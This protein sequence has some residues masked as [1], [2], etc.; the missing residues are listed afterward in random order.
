MDYYGGTRIGPGVLPH[1]QQLGIS[2]SYDEMSKKLHIQYLLWMELRKLKSHPLLLIPSW[3]G[4]F[5]KIRDN[6]VVIQ[7]TIGYLDTLDS[8]ATD[9]KTAYEVLCRG[10]EIKDRLQLK[11]VACVFD[12]AFYAKAMEVIWKQKEQFEGL[13][14]MMGG[15]HLLMTLLAIIGSRFG[16]AGLRDVAVHSEVIAEG[17][18]DSVLNGKHY[19]R[20]V[21]LHKIMY[22]AITKLLLDEFETSLFENSSELPSERKMQLEQVKLNLCQE[23][24]EQVLESELVQQWENCFQEHVT[25]I[26]PNIIMSMFTRVFF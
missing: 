24:I 3:T 20:G 13:V 12:Q 23:D 6:I 25:D 26:R 10:L 1:M 5:K 19:N 16:D 15:F 21:R 8:P 4:F 22:E 17:S 18:I 7:S 2:S 9:L 11:A 14:V